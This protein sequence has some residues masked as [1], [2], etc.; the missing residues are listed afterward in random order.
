[1][2][3]SIE[4]ER[5]IM[6][7]SDFRKMFFTSFGRKN[8]ETKVAIYEMLCPI[9][10]VDDPEL[11]KGTNNEDEYVSIGKLSNFIDF[12]NFAPLMMN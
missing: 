2:N 4:D 11:L 8:P 10:K 3:E 6:L 9:I 1:M 5:G 12:F 7:K